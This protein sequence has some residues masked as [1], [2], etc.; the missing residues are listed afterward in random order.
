[1]Y[2]L[3]AW[4]VLSLFDIENYTRSAVIAYFLS[5]YNIV[6][7]NG[8]GYRTNNMIDQCF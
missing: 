7:N 4:L 6:M 1:M 8:I 3:V 5:M 2:K